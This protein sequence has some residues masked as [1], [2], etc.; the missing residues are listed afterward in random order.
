MGENELYLLAVIVGGFNSGSVSML[1]W[2]L[3]RST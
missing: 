1:W 3:A 2:P